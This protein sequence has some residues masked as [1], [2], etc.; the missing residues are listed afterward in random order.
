MELGIDEALQRGVAAHKAGDL[1]EADKFYTAILKVQPQHPDA[2]HNMGV[3]AVSLGKVRDA[4][5]FFKTALEANPATE[6]FWLSYIDALIREQQ[7]I[8]ARQVIK[9]AKKHGVTTEKLNAL[10]ERLPAGGTIAG[11]SSERQQSL[12]NYFHDKQYEQAEK[13]ALSM[14]GDFPE[15][16]FGWKVLGAVLNETGRHADALTANQKAVEVNPENAE[17]HN[18]LGLTLRELKKLKEAEASFRSAISFNSDFA[19]GYNNLGLVLKELGQLEEAEENLR[20]AIKLKSDFVE[21]RVNL[22]NTFK[23]LNRLEEALT[24]YGQG[25]ALVP[26]YAD[27]YFNMGNT[28]RQL[29]KLHEAEISFNR[30]TALKP[31]YIEAIQNKWAVLFEKKDFIAA[32]KVCDSFNT[33]LLRAFRLE[34]LY[35]LGRIDE[36]YSRIEANAGIDET[37]MRVAAFSAFISEAEQKYTAHRFCNN[38]LDFLY[39]SNISAHMQNSTGFITDVINQLNDITTIWEPNGLATR[40]GFQTVTGENIFLAPSGNLSRLK[41]IIMDEVDKYYF[42]F[43]DETC[44]FIKKWPTGKK[45]NAWHV[46]LK[47][48]GHQ[49]EHIHP[50]GW[51]SGVIYLKVVPPLAKSEGAIQFTLNGDNYSND[52]GPTITY[53][54]KIGDIVLFPSSLHHKTIPFTTSSDRVIVSFDLKPDVVNE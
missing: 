5:S 46:V 23:N 42:K 4:L 30:A 18:N 38:P 11:P 2:N 20:H 37:N 34:T 48:S 36:I 45:L 24:Y 50:G 25:L 1:N 35:A 41:S 17:A 13:L 28:L 15:H 19:E 43:K 26:G 39:F 12:L 33:S 32:L 14:T 54:P 27:L 47:S 40:N 29:H 31:D 21:A 7:F 22:G 52:K 6:Q 51:V 10:A 8:G 44:S 16:G 9:Q 3:L 53:E 49:T